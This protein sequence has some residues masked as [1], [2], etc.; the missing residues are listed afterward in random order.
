MVYVRYIRSG[1]VDPP[2]GHEQHLRHGGGAE[3]RIPSF[4]LQ[5]SLQGRE[6]LS[7]VDVS[8]GRG[9]PRTQ[10]QWLWGGRDH[11]VP[12]LPLQEVRGLLSSSTSTFTFALRPPLLYLLH[13]RRLRLL[14]SS[15]TLPLVRVRW[16]SPRPV[17]VHFHG[18][19]ETA[20][21][22][23]GLVALYRGAGCSI[24][25]VD[26]RGYGWSTGTPSL[27]TLTS[28]AAAIMRH[29]PKILRSAG[30]QGAPCLLAGRSLG[31]ACAIELAARFEENFVGLILESAVMNLLELPMVAEAL[32]GNL[33]AS[34]P[35]PF[36]N[37]AKL[38][39]LKGLRVLMLHG[40]EDNLVPASQAETLFEACGV[41]AEQKELCL[42]AGCGHDDLSDDKK[43]ENVVAAFLDSFLPEYI[44]VPT[45][46]AEENEAA[47]SSLPSWVHCLGCFSHQLAEAVRAEVE[48]D[49]SSAVLR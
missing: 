8:A 49:S 40:L 1:G 46:V 3:A 19:A 14:A 25:A 30:L 11:R 2:L 9:V 31:S 32:G 42:I 38:A 33:A 24:L 4:L 45:S 36:L 12:P 16:S 7:E 37:A 44:G 20:A 41:T 22:M 47:S 27:V 21:D 15:P 6:P 39:R 18:N 13:L 26:F 10:R 17:I 23:D 29:L 5:L 34:L 35:D 48:G 43:Y 28:D